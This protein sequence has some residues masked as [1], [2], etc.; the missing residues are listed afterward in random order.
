MTQRVPQAQPDNHALLPLVD[1]V[2]LEC[3][4]PPACVLADAAFS[5]AANLQALEARGIEA[6]IPDSNLRRE[7]K[8][9]FSAEERLPLP[10]P[11]L[12][13][14]RH[15]RRTAAGRRQYYRRQG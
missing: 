1:A 4:Q 15:Q 9:N 13:A 7:M 5:S 11:R 14:M 3:Q 8:G 12:L 10:D 2:P 6:Y